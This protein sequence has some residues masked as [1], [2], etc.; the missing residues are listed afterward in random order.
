MSTHT[1]HPDIH[2]NGLADDCD[3]CAEHAADPFRGLDDSNLRDL[4]VRT[5]A[6]MRDD[7]LPRSDN[8]AKAMRV[9][10]Q[11]ILQARQIDRIA[12]LYERESA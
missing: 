5:A 8:E 2:D 12:P 9:M 3:R 4:Y 7:A 11:A 6:W 1:Y 10:E